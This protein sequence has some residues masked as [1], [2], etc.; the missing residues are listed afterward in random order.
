[1]STPREV[2]VL[3]MKEGRFSEAAAA[4]ADAVA[5]DPKDVGAWRLLGGALAALED[6]PGAVAAFQ[7]T[8]ALDPNQP[9]NHYNL[10]LSLQAAGDRSGARQHFTHA[11]AL[12]PGY[13]Q[14]T[15]RLRELDALPTVPPVRMA[16][17]PPPP[18]SA[19]SGG[20]VPLP[21]NYA[22]T[23]QSYTPPSTLDYGGGYSAASPGYGYGQAQRQ[24]ERPM[25]G[26]SVAPPVN[27]TNVLVMGILGLTLTPILSPFAWYH[28]KRALELLDQNP[29]AD[30]RQ[31]SNAQAGLVLG[32]VGTVLLALGAILL[33]L[34]WLGGGF[35]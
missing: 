8:V 24:Q 32:V 25:V 16:P 15:Q 19:P 20:R 1:M 26:T 34:V 4:L 21:P 13:E 10:A 9:K 2:G 17:P 35:R 23:N 30:Q 14:A 3:R 5:Q 22:P 18:T 12:D 31:R 33:W 28:G 27:G 6:T 29:Q 11:L 7:H